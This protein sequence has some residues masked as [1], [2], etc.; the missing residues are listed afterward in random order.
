MIPRIIFIII[1][2]SIALKLIFKHIKI[3]YIAIPDIKKGIDIFKYLLNLN[4][5][6]TYKTCM[7]HTVASAKR[8][9]TA[10]P[11]DAYIGIRI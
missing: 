10:A 1:F 8:V 11:N 6:L 9:A 3:K 2:T 4:R 5:C 7:I